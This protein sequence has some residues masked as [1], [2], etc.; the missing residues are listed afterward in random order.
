MQLFCLISSAQ[1]ATCSW[2]F[3]A[4]LSVII[5]DICTTCFIGSA[6]ISDVTNW[7]WISRGATRFTRKRHI[8]LRS[9]KFDHVSKNPT[10]FK[11]IVWLWER[12]PCPLESIGPHAPP[13]VRATQWN[14]R[15]VML[16][17]VRGYIVIL[18]FDTSFQLSVIFSLDARYNNV[19]CW[20]AYCF[21]C[22]FSIVFYLT[23]LRH[24][25][26]I[27]VSQFLYFIQ[28]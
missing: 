1:I 15:W 27:C 16:F 3:G 12:L 23:S 21:V 22:L 6:R 9:S 2:Y 19:F 10:V 14:P 5:F 13:N 24:Y 25:I 26:A 4:S 20:A 7:R 17:L 8:G 11:W 28:V 18:F